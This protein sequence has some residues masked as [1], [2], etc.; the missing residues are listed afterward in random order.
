[1]VLLPY[2]SN[3]RALPPVLCVY[4]RLLPALQLPDLPTEEVR[5]GEGHELMDHVA[6]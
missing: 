2:S 1:M 4:I 5:H 3:A 6:R